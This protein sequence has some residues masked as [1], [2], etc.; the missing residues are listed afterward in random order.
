MRH[1]NWPIK[2]RYLCQLRAI[3]RMLGYYVLFVGKEW[4][5]MRG[6][7]VLGCNM[8][9][10]CGGIFEIGVKEGVFQSNRAGWCQKPSQNNSKPY[11]SSLNSY[12]NTWHI[13]L[14]FFS[15][16]FPSF[17]SDMNLVTDSKDLWNVH[18]LPC[19]P[20]ETS[21]YSIPFQM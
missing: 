7:D 15:T 10:K 5:F 19:Y 4:V 16:F 11:S 2:N 20:S 18:C 6:K 3:G 14:S 21:I 1:L 13:S 12:N 17:S 8:W 9:M